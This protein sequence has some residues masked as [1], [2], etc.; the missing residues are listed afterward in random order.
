[1]SLSLF[2]VALLQHAEAKHNDEAS[3]DVQ[4]RP[5][6]YCASTNRKLWWVLVLCTERGAGVLHELFP[7]NELL[8]R[9]YAIK[10]HRL[11]IVVSVCTLHAAFRA[12]VSQRVTNRG[13]QQR[14]TAPRNTRDNGI[15]LRINSLLTMITSTAQSSGRIWDVGLNFPDSP[16]ADCGYFRV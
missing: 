5:L 3:T 7:C 11:T 9:T 13:G 1:M 12:L 15:L 14:Y 6:L 10:H 4:T 2:P 16:T 8:S